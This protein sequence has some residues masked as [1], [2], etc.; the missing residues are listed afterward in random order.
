M[1]E[2]KRLK[3]T[4]FN[5]KSAKQVKKFNRMDDKLKKIRSNSICDF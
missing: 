3:Y 5:F 2:T 1:E 4:K